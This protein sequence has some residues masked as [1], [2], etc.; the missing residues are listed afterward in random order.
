MDDFDN[1]HDLDQL[2]HR[3]QNG[4]RLRARCLVCK[5]WIDLK[6]GIERWD[7]VE[8]PECDTLHELTDL[9]PPTLSMVELGDDVD[10]ELVYEDDDFSGDFYA[11][12]DY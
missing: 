3:Q 8:C 9:H 10:D 1:T 7:L 6:E 5:T 2:S 4:P 12:D 11:D